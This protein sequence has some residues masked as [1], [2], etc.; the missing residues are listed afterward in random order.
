MNIKK[1]SAVVMTAAVLAAAAPI[2]SAL[3][4]SLSVTANAAVVVLKKRK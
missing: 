2:T 3:P 4:D 1:I